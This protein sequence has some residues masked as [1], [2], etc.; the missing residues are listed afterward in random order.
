M[1]IDGTLRENNPAKDRPGMPALK[2]INVIFLYVVDLEKA[3]DFYSKMLGLGEPIK[4]SPDWVEF[5]LEEGGVHLAL[6]PTLPENVEGYDR[7]RSTIKFSIVVDNL[8]EL[9]ERL[10]TQGVTFVRAPEFGCGFRLA[11][12]EDCEGNLLRLIEYDE[13]AE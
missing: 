11:E 10:K 13:A 8:N 2:R 3:A 7:S 9:Y 6:Q 12:L 1:E 5:A 4:Q